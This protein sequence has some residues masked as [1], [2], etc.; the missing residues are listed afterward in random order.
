M[1]EPDDPRVAKSL[2]EISRVLRLGFV[3]GLACAALALYLA[4]RGR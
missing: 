1:E 4:L 2:G 3:L